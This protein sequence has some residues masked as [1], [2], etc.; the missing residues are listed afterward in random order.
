MSKGC[1]RA[2]GY[3]R[4]WDEGIC[5]KFVNCIDG[6]ANEMPCPP[7][8]VYDDSASSCTWPTE[9]KRQ[10]TTTKKGILVLTYYYIINYNIRR[11]V[12][13]FLYF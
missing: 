12:L 6:V 11:L 5:D 1:P 2:N 4:H 9:S 7:G 10:C 8:L 3:Y 13:K